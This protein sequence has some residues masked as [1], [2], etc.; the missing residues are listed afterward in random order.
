MQTFTSWS[1]FLP[2]I[3]KSHI[4]H[5]KQSFF[6]F[7]SSDKIVILNYLN[8]IFPSQAVGFHWKKHQ[9]AHCTFY[10]KQRTYRQLKLLLVIS[11]PGLCHPPFS[12][13][14]IVQI[15]CRED[16]STD[17]SA[18]QWVHIK[19]GLGVNSLR[20]AAGMISDSVWLCV[21]LYVVYSDKLWGRK[22]ITELQNIQMLWKE[23]R[24]LQMMSW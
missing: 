15:Q 14:L 18:S 1:V 3:D 6:P 22:V 17:Q 23:L 13:L 4:W 11:P 8:L 19:R 5:T 21:G 7:L 24:V 2:F 9:E 10:S 20:G 16:F 12:T